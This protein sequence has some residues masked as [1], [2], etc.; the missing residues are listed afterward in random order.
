MR[1]R[2]MDFTDLV[3]RRASL[4]AKLYVTV[5]TFKRGLYNVIFKIF[6]YYYSNIC[7]QTLTSIAGIM[8]AIDK[9]SPF[10]SYCLSITFS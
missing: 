4:G 9:F 1:T 7:G 6:K 8:F 5:N 3:K 10:N 2:V